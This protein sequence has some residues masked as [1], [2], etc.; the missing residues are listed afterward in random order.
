MFNLDSES[1]LFNER[2]YFE[3]HSAIEFLV[4][5]SLSNTVDFTYQGNDL[6]AIHLSATD[7]ATDYILTSSLLCWEGEISKQGKFRVGGGSAFKSTCASSRPAPTGPPPIICNCR[8]YHL[9]SNLCQLYAYV[10]AL[11]HM[12]MQAKHSCP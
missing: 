8:R 5:A 1:F 7:F 4:P 2:E 12:Y 6:S 11:L 3:L 9:F 10:H